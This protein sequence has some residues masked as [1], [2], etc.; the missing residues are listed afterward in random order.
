MEIG[1]EGGCVT[2][3]SLADGTTSMYTSTGG[4][5]I[6]AG[7]MEG[8]ANASRQL[9]VE[10]QTQLDLF[11]PAE[12]CPLPGPGA[13]AFVVLTYDGIR[14]TESSEKRLADTNEPLHLLWMSANRVITEIRL[15]ETARRKHKDARS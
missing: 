2:F 7:Q 9:L 15:Q 5:V 3:V 14:R 11:P 6:G 4:G 13:V 12:A 1:L 10:L 8:P